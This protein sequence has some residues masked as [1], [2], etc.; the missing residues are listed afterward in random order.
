MEKTWTKPKGKKEGCQLVFSRATARLFPRGP[1]CPFP[2]A[3][4]PDQ[5]IPAPAR[6]MPW[7]GLR[8]TTRPYQ[9]HLDFCKKPNSRVIGQGHNETKA[10]PPFVSLA[11]RCERSFMPGIIAFPTVVE[12]ALEEFGGLFANAPERR[13]FGEYLTGLVV[14]ERKNVS[15]INAEFVETTDQSCLNR[16]ITQVRWDGKWLNE[17]RL[18]W[19][20]ERPSTRYSACGVIAIDNTLVKHSGEKIEEHQI[21]GDFAV[22][23]YFSSV[24]CLDH[25]HSYERGYVGA[26]KSNRKVE[27]Q[28]R[29]MKAVEVAASIPSEDRKR[30]C[31]GGRKQWYFG[32]LPR[33][34]AL[35]ASRSNRLPGRTPQTM[36]FHQDDAPAQARSPPSSGD[37]VGSQERQG[38]S[39]VSGHQPRAMGDPS[40]TE[41][42][43][44]TL[45]GHRDLSSGRQAS[46]GHGRL[47]VTQRRGPDPAYVPRDA[48]AQSA[49]GADAAGPCA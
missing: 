4:L 33:R 42:V 31:I 6:S 34:C 39:Q 10:S 23:S 30:V 48:G 41:R 38:S 14:A 26:L 1:K 47:S 29:Q 49:Y 27:F 12:E 7:P 16:W 13:H 3:D 45:D 25:I 8:A 43:S 15:T 5:M 28:G 32:I 21:P 22:D 2:G 18:E 46:S 17:H 19:L 44:Q 11:I 36:V 24:E 40:Y 35:P 9:L 37:P 20:Q